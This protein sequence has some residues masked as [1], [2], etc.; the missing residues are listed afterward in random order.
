MSEAKSGKRSEHQKVW[1]DVQSLLHSLPILT[2]F[3]IPVSITCLTSG[4][5]REVSATFVDTITLTIPSAMSG[6]ERSKRKRVE[7]NVRCFDFSKNLTFG[8][9]ENSPLLVLGEG[10]VN[11]KTK[12]KLTCYTCLSNVVFL[13][14]Y[15]NICLT[16]MFQQF[17]KL[18]S[19]SNHPSGKL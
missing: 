14:S 4:I 2:S 5:V 1:I 12:H 15:E 9:Y 16:L 11:E 7:T 18:L 8:D 6:S 19:T 17:N 10:G 13:H 3:T